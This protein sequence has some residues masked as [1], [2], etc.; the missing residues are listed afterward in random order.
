[1]C[2]YRI[3][4]ISIENDLLTDRINGENI[5]NGNFYFRKINNG[6]ILSNPPIFDCFSLQ[7]FEDNKF[8]G[9][10]LKDVY[11]GIGVFPLGN[12]LI[13]DKL[14]QLLEMYI[15]AKEYRFYES[16]LLYKG[17]KY[18]YW[19]FQ[20]TAI[21]R[22]LNKTRYIDFGKSIFV[23]RNRLER[24]PKLISYADYL[25]YEYELK[26]KCNDV[27]LLEKLSLK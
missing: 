16:K 21:Y 24:L 10:C 2:F 15:I 27:I 19:L 26:N 9:M 3:K 14:K 5:H 6:E 25:N 17:E 12:W 11:N 7:S 1:M 8:L 23:P 18:I 4:K 22:K 20:F 13:S